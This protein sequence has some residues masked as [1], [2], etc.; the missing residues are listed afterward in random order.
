MVAS[1]RMNLVTGLEITLSTP[2]LVAPSPQAPS[3]VGMLILG[4]EVLAMGDLVPVV[5]DAQVR[6]VAVRAPV[7]DVF[8]RSQTWVMTSQKSLRSNPGQRHRR[9]RLHP[10]Y[11]LYFRLNNSNNGGSVLKRRRGDCTRMPWLVS[12]R[13]RASSRCL[14]LSRAHRLARCVGFCDS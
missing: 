14:P 2:Y 8:S 10:L 1:R 4:R 5:A 13:Y 11:P 6:T 3:P 9:N 7:V 12:N